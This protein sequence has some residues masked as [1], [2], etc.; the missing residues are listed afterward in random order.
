MQGQR[1]ERRP[2]G[3]GALDVGP[4]LLVDHQISFEV[5]PRRI[6]APPAVERVNRAMKQ[7]AVAGETNRQ[8]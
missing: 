5:A 1:V 6:V 7:L 8:Q 2:G 3:L 4:P